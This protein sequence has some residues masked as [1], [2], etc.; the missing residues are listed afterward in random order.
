M[1][2]KKIK[3]NPLH[4]MQV[5][6]DIDNMHGSTLTAMAKAVEDADIVMVCCSKGYKDSDNCRA[7]KRKE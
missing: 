7:G 1:F 3:K 6:M 2:I 5:W 4:L